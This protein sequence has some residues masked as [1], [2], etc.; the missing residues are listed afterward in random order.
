MGAAQLARNGTFRKQTLPHASLSTS[1]FRLPTVCTDR[2]EQVITH[3]PCGGDPERVDG[4]LYISATIGGIDGPG[5][6]TFTS[7]PI[8]TRSACPAISTVGRIEIDRD[9]I[10]DFEANNVL[11]GLVLREMG[12]VIGVGYVNSL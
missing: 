6:F 10:G 12:R 3:Q 1:P 5:G 2:W 4:E 9:D 8:A 11:D 7:T